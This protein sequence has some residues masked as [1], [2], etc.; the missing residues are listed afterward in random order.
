MRL[1][2]L[3]KRTRVALA[4]AAV[5]PLLALA[6][7]S[8]S[9]SATTANAAPTNGT[10]TVGLLGDIGQPPDPD[11]YYANNGLAIVLN[12]YEGLVQYAND[13]DSVKI[14]PRLATSG[15]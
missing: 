5:L 9:G 12:T 3:R 4:A 15:T 1:S 10:L 6:A 2:T 13:T 7:C 11:I 14:A 8:G